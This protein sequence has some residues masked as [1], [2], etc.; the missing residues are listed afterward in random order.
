MEDIQVIGL[1][2]RTYA[3]NCMPKGKNWK[4]RILYGRVNSHYKKICSNCVKAEEIACCH[5]AKQS[6]SSI[7]V[8]K[9]TCR[10][11]Q[12]YQ[13]RCLTGR[14]RTFDCN[15]FLNQVCTVVSQLWSIWQSWITLPN[16]WTKDSVLSRKCTLQAWKA[17]L[18]P[19]TQ[20]QEARLSTL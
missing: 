7:T 4:S 9:G 5:R 3:H 13:K 12:V 18:Y 19:Q 20:Q 6:L 14:A 16:A 11:P 15:E 8:P 17:R 1:N 2:S 10:Q